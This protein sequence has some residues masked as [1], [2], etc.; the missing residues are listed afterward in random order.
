ML[1]D[2]AFAELYILDVDRTDVLALML[3]V[4]FLLV[5]IILWY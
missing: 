3:K 5:W 1:Y 4:G 2:F